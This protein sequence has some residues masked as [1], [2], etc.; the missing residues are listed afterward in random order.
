MKLWQR[1]APLVMAGAMMTGA[2]VGVSALAMASPANA[3]ITCV[4][5][6]PATN[7]TTP[8]GGIDIAAYLAAVAAFNA[9]LSGTG[10]GAGTAAGTAAGPGTSTPVARALAFT[11][12]DSRE[13]GALGLAIVGIGAG[14]IAVSRRRRHAEAL[15]DADVNS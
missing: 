11:G 13:L 6:G 10:A 12:S 7:F 15:V 5:P 4:D 3:A 2:T 1:I 9:C 8:S 14:A